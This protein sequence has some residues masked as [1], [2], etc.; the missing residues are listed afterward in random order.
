[1]MYN[2]G[3]KRQA[4]VTVALRLIVTLMLVMRSGKW[5]AVLQMHEKLNEILHFGNKRNVSNAIRQV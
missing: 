3:E 1:M 4:S 5:L 2:L